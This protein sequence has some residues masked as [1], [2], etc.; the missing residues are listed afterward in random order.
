MRKNI[1]V[2][3]TS[4]GGLDA[5][6]AIFSG[7]PQG[8][9]A[10]IFVV[11]HTSPNSPGLLAQILDRAGPLPALMIE[12]SERIREG[13]VYVPPPDHHLIVSPGVVSATKGPKENRFRPAVDPLFRSA[14]QTYGPRVIGVV[15]TGGLDDGTAGLW[16]IKRLG[17]TAVVQ[18]PRDALAPSMPRS[19]LAHVDVDHRL[20]LSAI[21]PLLVRLASE[22]AD[23]KGDFVMPKGLHTEVQIAKTANALNEG[24]TDLGEPSQFACPECHGVLLQLKEGSRIRFRCHTGHAYSAESLLAEVDEVTEDALWNA[25]RSLEES[26]RLRQHLATH[27]MP[28]ADGAGAALLAD[29]ARNA[30][31]RASLVRQAVLDG[32]TTPRRPTNEAGSANG[33]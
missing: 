33:D 14:A 5:L 19:A 11:L 21:A 17:G 7:L 1:I 13:V 29:A 27:A 23:E 4:T 6:K 22:S 31:R 26:A 9:A 24:V 15:L 10:S 3:G 12:S 2:I 28:R 8:F 30:H 20:P 18:D 25:I 16:A 32:P